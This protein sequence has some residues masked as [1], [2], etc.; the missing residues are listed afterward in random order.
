MV[1]GLVGAGPGQMHDVP[2]SLGN[3][4]ADRRG[5]IQRRRL[6]RTRLAA[7]G[8]EKDGGCTKETNESEP[9]AY[10]S[11]AEEKR[12]PVVSARLAVRA[13]AILP[14]LEPVTDRRS[15]SPGSP[16]GPAGRD[17]W[18]EGC[19]VPSARRVFA[20]RKQERSRVPGDARLWP[21]LG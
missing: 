8:C 5:Q 2:R 14:V 1:R 18:P 7:A 10:L 12:P 20:A 4:I 3:E 9:H 13:R 19:P 6:R 21:E 11:V 16:A 15:E 17:C